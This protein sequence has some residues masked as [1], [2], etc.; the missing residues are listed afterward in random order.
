[1]DFLS[2]R[3]RRPLGS[4]FHGIRQGG[5]LVRN[6]NH[7][8]TRRFLHGR[9]RSGLVIRTFRGCLLESPNGGAASR[10]I[11]GGTGCSLF[12]IWLRFEPDLP[13]AGPRGSFEGWSPDPL[14]LAAEPPTQASQH[15]PHAQSIHCAKRKD[16]AQRGHI[17]ASSEHIDRIGNASDIARG[18]KVKA[19][20][21]LERSVEEAKPKA[22]TPFQFLKPEAYDPTHERPRLPLCAEETGRRVQD[23]KPRGRGPPIRIGGNIRKDRPHF[24]RSERNAQGF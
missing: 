11:L 21:A 4:G 19:A 8:D 16:P 2:A 14:S 3:A 7:G 6:P 23:S 17:Q 10:F 20:G 1:V 15:A 18:R 22:A 24:F 5:G 13:R 9:T 12:P